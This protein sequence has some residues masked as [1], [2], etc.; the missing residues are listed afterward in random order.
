MSCGETVHRVP[1]KRVLG[2]V[3]V[4]LVACG[5]AEGGVIDVA[6]DFDAG[7]PRST[8]DDAQ[9]VELYVVSGCEQI[10]LGG[11]PDDEVAST[12]VLR[13]GTA[14]PTLGA[15]EPGEYGLYARAQDG[16]CAV[17]A[18]GCNDIAIT[19]TTGGP[20]EVTMSGFAGASC[21]PNE[22]CVIESGDCVEISVGGQCD[23]EPDGTSC[24]T[25]GVDGLCR[26]EACCTGCWNGSSCLPGNQTQNC[27]QG[28]G[29]CE[30]V[31]G[32]PL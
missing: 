29:M 8:V 31:P 16:T 32:C 9:R 19:A 27:G 1:L 18:A 24:M 7:L 21:Q 22:Q 17:V 4:A 6:V 25:E 15:I 3:L 20:V 2:C 28:G 26:N 11:R 10:A 14:G 13:D 30:F 5:D 23:G 12:V